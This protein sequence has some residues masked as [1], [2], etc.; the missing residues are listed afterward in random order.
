MTPVGT[1]R[2]VLILLAAA[3][4][5]VLAAR[6]LRVPE[7]IAFVVGGMVLALI[8]S[9]PHV[10][11]D[12]D[13]TMVLFL[14]PLLLAGGFTTHVREFRRHL[15]PILLL[16]V[17]AVAFTTLAVGA[18][19]KLLVPDLPWAA[20]F[21]FGAIVS[22]TDAVAA[23]AIM[24]QIRLPRRIITI[25]E[26]ESLVNDASGLVLYRMAVAATLT[27]TFDAAGASLSFIWL[28]VA[29]IATG[30]VLGYAFSF[31]VRVLRD[32]HLEIAATFLIAWGG[33]ILAEAAG[34]SGVLATVT[35]GLMMG[36][37]QHDIASPRTRVAAA[38]T[39][40][41]VL[42]VLH[43]LVFI[44]IGLSLNGVLNRLGELPSPHLAWL[45]V[46]VSLAV[47]ASRFV[48][49]YPLIYLRALISRPPGPLAAPNVPFVISWSGMRGVVS[50]AVALA[51]P[52][53][54][55]GRDM[56]L[57]LTFCVI[58]ATL[59]VQG[60][61]LRPLL[62]WLQFAPE[63][64][65]ETGLFSQALV[66]AR[67]AAASLRYI[68]ERAADPLDGAMAKDLLTEFRDQASWTSRADDDGAAGRAEKSARATLRLGALA[69]A[70]EAL[71]RMHHR[72][73]IHE[74]TLRTIEGDMDLEE[75]R[76][77]RMLG[78]GD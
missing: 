71:L 77:R 49:V 16:A 50:L 54:M 60:L 9:A 70:R 26:G 66:Q 45:G 63:K 43:A 3:V 36:W 1:L 59:V 72:R 52:V 37:M 57:F 35:S 14:P 76:L 20:C 40:D 48:W 73:E 56:I 13:L 65:Q 28:V 17:G 15:S 62:A 44:L 4:A 5:L 47:I 8:P 61:T 23:L 7:A 67:L 19:L 69:A 42:F 27:G 25:L 41:F 32:T 6:K 18:T 2:L 75:V 39:W 34:G 38:A 21:T 33:Y 64:A 58:L 31:G 22:P 10:A 68:E 46:A 78:G 29:G 53:E 74:E 55:P 11:L 24:R 51:L 30:A 12:P